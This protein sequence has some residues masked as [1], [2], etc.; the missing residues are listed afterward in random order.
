MV[1]ELARADA[2]GLRDVDKAFAAL[3]ESTGLVQP[4]DRLGV[5]A[6]P[7][8]SL[9]SSGDALLV[10]GLPD[11]PLRDAKPAGDLFHRELLVLIEA[12]DFCHRVRDGMPV[13]HFG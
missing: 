6:A 4:G 12:H 8:A 7:E 1:A 9:G 13:I 11:P 3:V 5:V 10:Q 2:Q